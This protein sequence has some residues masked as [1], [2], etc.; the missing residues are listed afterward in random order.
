MFLARNTRGIQALREF[1]KLFNSLTAHE[2]VKALT[3]DRGRV[4][5]VFDDGRQIEKCFLFGPPEF[6]PPH[7]TST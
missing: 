4:N 6:C 1:C 7:L 5:D 2:L 3:P